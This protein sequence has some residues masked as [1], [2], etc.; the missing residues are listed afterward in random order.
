MKVVILGNS[1]QLASELRAT[2]PN[3][4][5]AEYWGHS[6]LDLGLLAEIAPA[7]KAANPDVI[8]NTAAYTAVDNAETDTDTATLINANAPQLVAETCAAINAKLFHVSTDFVFDGSNDVPYQPTDS[9]RPLSVYGTTKLA[10]E[11][12]VLG[13]SSEATI[14]RTAWVFSQYGKNFVKTMLNLMS[15]RDQLSIVSDQ[16]GSPTWA[17][18]LALF[19]WQLT[20]AKALPNILH[21][22]NQGS[23]S[24]FEFAQFIQQEALSLGLLS[25]CCTL[26]PIPSSQYPT[27]AKR[28][29]Y[30]VLNCTA[31]YRLTE[32]AAEWQ[33][34]VRNMLIAMSN[35]ST[36][37]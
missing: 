36:Q 13:A 1:G 14:I 25:N 6:K 3:Q 10:G 27:A 18:E 30:S 12:A 23:C 29:A 16:T 37:D 22:T 7:I 9:T 34:A 2:Q 4:I 26:L 5:V 17:R 15:T 33:N 20:H 28:P 11:T 19:I 31:S 35:L 24:W 21:W 8:I 32:P